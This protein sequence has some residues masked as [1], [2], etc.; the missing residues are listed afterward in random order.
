MTR[1]LLALAL[2]LSLVGP[3]CGQ[4]APPLGGPT[5]DPSAKAP[6]LIERDYEGRLRRLDRRPEI[7]AVD[8]LDLT[9]D[10]RAAADE[11]IADR[12]ALTE[13][14]VFQ[15]LLLLT[16]ISAALESAPA[17]AGFEALE[18][19]LRG[20][21]ESRLSELWIGTPLADQIER[22]LPE[23]ERIEYRRIVNVWFVAA[24]AEERDRFRELDATPFELV[25]RRIVGAEIES[26]YERGQ[27]GRDDEFEQFLAKLKLDAET[28]GRV[29]RAA[30]D[31]YLKVF[32]ETGREPNRDEESAIFMAMLEEIP[33][34]DHPRVWRAVLGVPAAD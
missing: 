29:R 14:V 3:A 22:A 25:V 32:N 28:E 2:L 6:S 17:G 9:A 7:A 34:V 12:A 13:R 11:V 31:A 26:A 4:D 23:S 27:A 20:R 19:E 1:D 8:L 24:M 10:Q 18:P 16:E 5:I 15:N 33:E 21:A 30:L